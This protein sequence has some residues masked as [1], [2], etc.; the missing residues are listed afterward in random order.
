MTKIWVALN[1]A[2]ALSGLWILQAQPK[3]SPNFTGGN[4]ITLT[5]GNQGAI[6]HFRFEP[7]VRTKWH[8]HSAGQ[9]ILVEEGVGLMQERGGPIIELHEGET[10]F[11]KPG[12]QHWHGSS[13]KAGGV[14][15]NV[16]RGE[17]TWLEEVS[18]KDFNGPTKRLR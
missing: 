3:Q 6:A 5:E 17:I 1:A 14:Q 16:T 10:I 8:S 13:P 2:A 7:G 9:I 18:D 15:Y 12:V 4:P 11:C